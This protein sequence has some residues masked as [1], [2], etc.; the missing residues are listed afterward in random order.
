MQILPQPS[1]QSQA[2]TKLLG[3]LAGP[4]QERSGVM[5]SEN[6]SN[7][8]GTKRLI[9]VRS[10][11]DIGSG[12]EVRCHE[13]LAERADSHF[14]SFESFLAEAHQTAKSEQNIYGQEFDLQRHSYERDRGTAC[15]ANR[16]SA[17]RYRPLLHL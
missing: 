3:N 1:P 4:L 12:T 13:L 10:A 7:N 17:W 6:A 11:I 5:N 15:G 16:K 14:G 8:A 2:P 9:E